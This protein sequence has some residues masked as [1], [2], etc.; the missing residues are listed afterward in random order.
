[1]H[2]GHSPAGDEQLHVERGEKGVETKPAAPRVGERRQ[3][4]DR[5]A[6]KQNSAQCEPRS[7]VDEPGGVGE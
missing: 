2:L 3:E 5:L 7:V 4:G 1:V 6:A